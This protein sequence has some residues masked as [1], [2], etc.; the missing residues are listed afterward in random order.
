MALISGGI[1]G[2]FNGLIGLASE[3]IEDKDKR[4]AFEFEAKT[5]Q[6][7]TIQTLLS[8]QTV[9]WVDAVVKLIYA[10]ISLGRPLA[11][12]AAF[13]IGVFNPDL[14][15]QLHS[16]GTVGDVAIGAI[17]GSAPAWGYSRHVEKRDQRKAEQRQ[18]EIE[19]QRVKVF[20]PLTGFID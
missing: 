12:F 6:L 11:S 7:Q 17:F 9:P 8:T 1:V 15:Q 5:L 14:I 4:N 2:A 10:M 20:D 13:F 19:S 16:V 3:F 18:V